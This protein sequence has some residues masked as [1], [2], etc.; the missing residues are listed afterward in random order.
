VSCK[1]SQYA[2]IV[3]YGTPSVFIDEL[4]YLDE[5]IARVT[6]TDENIVEFE[7]FNPKSISAVAKIMAINCMFSGMSRMYICGKR[8]RLN[9][10]DG[11]NSITLAPIVSSK[12][13]ANTNIG[14]LDCLI[15]G[16]TVTRSVIPRGHN[17]VR[18][19]S[20]TRL[21]F[22]RSGDKLRVGVEISAGGCNS[23]STPTNKKAKDA[24]KV[25]V[26]LSQ[27]HLSYFSA[28]QDSKDEEGS[29][30]G[31]ELLT[32]GYISSYASSMHKMRA[33]TPYLSI[34]DQDS[35][36]GPER[37]ILTKVLSIEVD[38]APIKV[39][40]GRARLSYH[41]PYEPLQPSFFYT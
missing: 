28:A 25:V 7:A 9:F 12:Q 32:A 14:M 34:S 29:R 23:H 10:S 2:S 26:G 3:R 11:N 16:V 5:M 31:V 8:T 24:V 20:R 17:P 39:R 40:T 6:K 33:P 37:H 21:R 35:S 41:I 27:V 36:L 18:F 4:W 19:N 13:Y 22:G 30:M 38:G 1:F 15:T